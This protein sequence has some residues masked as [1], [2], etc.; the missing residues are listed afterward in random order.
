MLSLIVAAAVSWPMT[1]LDETSARL[2][3][4]AAAHDATA[5]AADRA[6]IVR[7]DEAVL[8]S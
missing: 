7:Q 6:D 8:T 1:P 5:F 4:D 2:V 3:Q